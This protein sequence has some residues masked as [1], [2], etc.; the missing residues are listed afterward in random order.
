[1]NSNRPNQ[2]LEP[3]ASRSDAWLFVDLPPFA[4]CHA[5]SQSLSFFS[6]G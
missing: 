4:R 1:M 6:L 5:R 2:A 3:T